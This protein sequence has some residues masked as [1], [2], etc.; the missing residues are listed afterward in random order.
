MTP[1]EKSEKL[2][3][4]Y[5]LIKDC[6]QC[7]LAASRTKFVFGS[8]NA[9]SK[10][11]FV[12]E[13]PGKNEDLQGKPFVGQ[14]GRLLDELLD[15]IGYKRIEVFIANV[16]KCRP[17]QN[18]DPL[19]EEIHLC[20]NY[21]LE[22]IEIIDPLIICTLGK[23]STQLLLGTNEGITG[24][25]GRVFNNGSR[26]IMPINH[27][28]AVLYAPSR[29]EILKNDFR[30]IEKVISLIKT[31][32]TDPLIEIEDCGRLKS[33]KNSI[34]AGKD[35]KTEE[36]SFGG[37]IENQVN[38]DINENTAKNDDFNPEQMGLF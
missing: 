32:K 26:Y 21:L 35:L 10:I 22:Q 8:G 19:Q 37:N 27:P 9:N 1:E 4:Y 28:A 6:C 36:K 5:Y 17:P 15:L 23:Y 11:M 38:G 33:E 2:K 20:K 31:G 24:L 14:A 13:A 16:L 18:R 3:Q 29:F 12:G 30:K 7:D 25:R 34:E